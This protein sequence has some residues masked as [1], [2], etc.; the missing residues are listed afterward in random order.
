MWQTIFQRTEQWLDQT[1]ASTQ[2][3]QRLT[4]YALNII[5][6]IRVLKTTED[7]LDVRRMLVSVKAV[8]LDQY[9]TTFFHRTFYHRADFLVENSVTNGLMT[10]QFSEVRGYSM[11]RVQGEE[12]TFDKC[13]QVVG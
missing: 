9:C 10:G 2:F 8:A 1:V 13:H 3:T 7:F 4:A 5:F 6:Q 12:F 11:T